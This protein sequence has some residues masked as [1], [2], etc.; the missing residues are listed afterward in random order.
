LTSF[1]TTFNSFCKD[2]FLVGHLYE[3]CHDEFSFFHEASTGPE[4]HVCY[5]AFTV[6]EIIRYENL[7]ALNDIHYVIPSIETVDVNSNTSILLDVHKDQ[8]ASC[9]NSEFIE[10]MLSTVDSSP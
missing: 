10:H 8:H 3:I 2:Y 5:E 6:E 9:E 7:E 1:H 4:N